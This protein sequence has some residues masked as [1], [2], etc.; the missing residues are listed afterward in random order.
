MVAFKLINHINV[1]QMF[2]QR[3]FVDV[4]DVGEPP[5]FFA[6]ESIV[7]S[8]VPHDEIAGH[9]QICRERIRSLFD[10]RW[11]PGTADMSDPPCSGSVKKNVTELVT[12]GEALPIFVAVVD[13]SEIDH[14]L[15]REPF[16]RERDASY[17]IGF[18][19]D[20]LDRDAET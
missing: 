7:V 2:Y 15:R 16:S 19:L 17:R 10:T 14:D 13:M 12:D 6:I 3:R 1:V 9:Q 5:Y 18:E 8:K 4:K 11:R 20:V